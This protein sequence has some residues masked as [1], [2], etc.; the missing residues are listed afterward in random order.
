[1]MFVDIP[2]HT[3]LAA[4]AE[5]D[6]DDV[7]IDVTPTAVLLIGSAADVVADRMYAW[8]ENWVDTAVASVFTH[9]A[10]RRP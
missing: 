9:P 5:V 10:R 6:T 7:V 2:P 3:A 1:M 8:V 4:F